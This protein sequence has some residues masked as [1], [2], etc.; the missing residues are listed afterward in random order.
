[1]YIFNIHIKM[2]FNINERE[3]KE[4]IY[5]TQNSWIDRIKLPPEL[6]EIPFDQ[7]W[8]E[9]PEEYEE[10]EMWGK[11]YNTP[12]WQKNYGKNYLY[13]G[14]E[15]KGDVI[16]IFFRPFFEWSKNKNYGDFN[17]MLV[18]WYENGHHYIGWHSDNEK[19]I[20]NETPIMSITLGDSNRKFR[21][22]IKGS[23][24]YKDIELFNGDVIIMGGK[25]QKECNHCLPKIS[26]NKGRQ[27]PKRI[28][29]TFRILE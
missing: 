25:F 5:V 1:M 13:S 4:R 17:Q 14:I 20:K 2:S 11:K 15:H 26:G 23:K 27:V 21:Y 19:N 29:I 22:K 3:N 9:H 8:S 10:I 28:N 7:L 24:E 6:L 16:P 12:R 18:N